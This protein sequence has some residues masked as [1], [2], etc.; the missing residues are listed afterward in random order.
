MR[1][2]I[3]LKILRARYLLVAT[4]AALSALG[5]E[6][7]A[8]AQTP[9]K[10]APAAP[11]PAKQDSTAPAA[12][13]GVT[14]PAAPPASGSTSLGDSLTGSAKAA[15]DLARVL[16]RAGDFAGALLQFERAYDLSSEPRLLWN[17]AVCE[18]NLRRYARSVKAIERYQAEGGTRLSEEDQKDAVH[19]LKAIRP[20]V[21]VMTVKVSEPGA[22]VFIDGERVGSTPLAGP[23][24]IDM[25]ARRIRVS[26]KGFHEHTQ[27][28]QVFGESE[29][30]LDIG[31]KKEIHQG[32][33]IIAAGKDDVIRLDGKVVGQ[34]SWDGTALSGGHTLRVTAPGMKPYQTEVM[35]QDNVVR[36]IQVTLDPEPKPGVPTWAL[37]TGSAVLAVG[38]GVGLGYFAW[39]ASEAPEPVIG[40]LG[41]YV[42]KLQ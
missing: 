5:A 22:D 25:G 34:G 14:G 16:Y 32:R 26:K 8:I 33:L 31:L 9:P 17:V 37:I 2:M 21:A 35:V 3:Y 11:L 15:Y 19:L 36:R 1:A 7:G 12:S 4:A 18:K 40:N 24:L 6:G 13:A 10:P 42:V 28:E 20:F 39:R 23:L 27:T 29:L 38:A 41:P 30:T